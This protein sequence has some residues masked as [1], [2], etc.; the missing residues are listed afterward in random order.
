MKMKWCKIV[1]LCGAAASLLLWYRFGA[2]VALG[3]TRA[4][5]LLFGITGAIESYVQK[6]PG[7]FKIFLVLTVLQALSLIFYLR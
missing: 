3:M 1:L 4:A 7:Y 2:K 5:W 6:K